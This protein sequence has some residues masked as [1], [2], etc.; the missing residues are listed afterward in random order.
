MT[1]VLVKICGLNDPA[2]VRAAAEAG[3]DMVGFMFYPRSPRAV[4]PAR[5]A[6]LARGLPAGIVRVAVLVDPD[7]ALVDAV[8]ATGVIDLLQL[9]G[10]ETPERI[11]A[12]KARTGLPVMKVLPVADRADVEAAAAYDGVVDRIMFDARPPKDMAGAL[13]GGNALS[14]DW[15]LLV[16][17]RLATPWTLAGGL[18]VE[19]VAEAVRLTGAGSVD[20]SSGVEDRPGVKSPD[21]I[22]AFVA[23]AKAAGPEAAQGDVGGRATLAPSAARP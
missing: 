23:A 19:N 1:G 13:P 16:G 6:E 9:H 2:A 18:T 14:F 5:V 3:A 20:T 8:T 21:K 4:T 15:R 11:L 22:R 7:D 17:L 12:L 10:R